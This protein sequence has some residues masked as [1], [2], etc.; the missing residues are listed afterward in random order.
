MINIVPINAH[1][2]GLVLVLFSALVLVQ[3]EE[4][5][6]RVSEG[7][8]FFFVVAKVVKAST[9]LELPSRKSSWDPFSRRDG[10][11]TSL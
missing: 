2:H 8:Y 3:L 7:V 9:L 6:N 10:I 1:R 4:M 5:D 11:W